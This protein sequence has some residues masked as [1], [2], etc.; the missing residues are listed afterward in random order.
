[1]EY[2]R[3]KSQSCKKDLQFGLRRMVVAMHYKNPI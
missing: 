1:V 2:H 3:L